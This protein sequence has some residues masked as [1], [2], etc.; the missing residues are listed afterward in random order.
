MVIG[1]GSFDFV[2][3]AFGD[4]DLPRL[5]GKGGIDH[6]TSEASGAHHS[7]TDTGRHARAYRDGAQ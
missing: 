4:G 5:E 1:L 7:G 6:G 2:A 3:R